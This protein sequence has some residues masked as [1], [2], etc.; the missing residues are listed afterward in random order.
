M[1]LTIIRK[2][3]PPPLLAQI[4]SRLAGAPWVD[5]LQTAG[6]VAA[7]VKRNLQVEV[8]SAEAIELGE[9]VKKTV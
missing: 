1:N 9:L 5:G 4:T 6:P 3:L 8:T 7:R 2:L